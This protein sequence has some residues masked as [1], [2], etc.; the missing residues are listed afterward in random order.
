MY[1]SI[2]QQKCLSTGLGILATG[3]CMKGADEKISKKSGISQAFLGYSLMKRIICG[4][5]Y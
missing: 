5:I 3:S 2:L 1:H 4:K